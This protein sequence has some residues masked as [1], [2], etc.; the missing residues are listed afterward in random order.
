MKNYTLEC[1]EKLI[2][3]Y[4]N[5]YGGNL[6]EVRDGILG[7]GTTLLYGAEGKKTVV[8]NEYYISE[9]S[10]G[11]TVRRYNKIPKKYQILIDKQ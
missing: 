2:D 1:C 10:S 8:I 11:H 7:L 6:L 5:S 4:I 9:C 3:I